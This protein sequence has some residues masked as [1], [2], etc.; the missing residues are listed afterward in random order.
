MRHSP[1]DPQHHHHLPPAH[2]P[3]RPG[4]AP[5][6]L[7]N[8]LHARLELQRRHGTATAH[9]RP[10]SAAADH[11]RQLRDRRSADDGRRDPCHRQRR[12][13]VRVH[14]LHP[15]PPNI[16]TTAPGGAT[17]SAASASITDPRRQPLPRRLT[18][19]PKSTFAR[20]RQGLSRRSAPA[21][22]QLSPDRPAHP[23]WKRR[24]HLSISARRSER[25]HVRRR[26]RPSSV[27]VRSRRGRSLILRLL[28]QPQ[29][30]SLGTASADVRRRQASGAGRDG[31]CGSVWRRRLSFSGSRTAV[32]STPR[33]ASSWRSPRRG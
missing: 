33:L 13:L 4:V 25:R 30:A 6:V 18:P 14:R 10:V 28:P 19:R 31:S 12:R 20:R 26:N 21:R 11:P 3:A 29:A 9:R 24:C 15:R 22:Q 2:H 8:R 32:T 7:V 27:A 23:C 5:G 16:P 17:S 1:R